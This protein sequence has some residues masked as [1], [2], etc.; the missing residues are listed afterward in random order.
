V[1]ATGER[2]P[3]IIK[4]RAL[5]A[6][7]MRKTAAQGRSLVRSLGSSPKATVCLLPTHRNRDGNLVIERLIGLAVL[8][9]AMPHTDFTLNSMV[10]IGDRPLCPLCGEP[11]WLVRVHETGPHLSERRFECATCEMA[12]VRVRK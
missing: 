3:K 2:D 6:L 9:R 7:G 1:T 12:D 4:D 8:E 10:F 5:N 11:M